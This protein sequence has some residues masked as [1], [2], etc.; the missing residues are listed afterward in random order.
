LDCTAAVLL[1][2]ELPLTRFE[3]VEVGTAISSPDAMIAFLL[4]LV[5]IVG[6][7]VT[8]KRPVASSACTVV[9]RERVAMPNCVRPLLVTRLAPRDANAAAAVDA[10]A[11]SALEPETLVELPGAA[12]FVMIERGS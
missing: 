2:S 5:K 9:A 11:P 3:S 12:G 7:C 10:T 1:L 8:R 6:R 4:L